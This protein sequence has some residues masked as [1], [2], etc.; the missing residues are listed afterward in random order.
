MS[1]LSLFYWI[2]MLLWFVLG[3]WV[4]YPNVAKAYVPSILLFLL[5]VIIGIRLFPLSLH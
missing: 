3:A 5:M 4:N 2:I 1:P